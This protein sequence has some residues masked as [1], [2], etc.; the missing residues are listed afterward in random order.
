MPD[1][2]A[3][4][5]SSDEWGLAGGLC[6]RRGCPEPGSH[7]LA[8]RVPNPAFPGDRRQDVLAWCILHRGPETGIVAVCEAHLPAAVALWH[9]RLHAEA[10][11]AAIRAM[12]RVAPDAAEIRF[13]VLSL[14]SSN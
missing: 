4:T 11:V 7:R 6:C 12:G 2:V 3:L 1:I 5:G 14:P 8:L 9:T 13:E 10:A